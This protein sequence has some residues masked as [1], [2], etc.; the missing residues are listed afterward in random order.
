MRLYQKLSE[1][2][3]ILEEAQKEA[4]EVAFIARGDPLFFGIGRRLLERFGPESLEI[5]PAL[6]VVQQASARLKIPWED[7]WVIS[8]HGG[9]K[10][11][12][13]YELSEIPGLL[14]LYGKLAVFTDP[15][16]PP[17]EILAYLKERVPEEELEVWVAERLGYP[18]ERLLSGSA[19]ELSAETFR[20]PNLLFLRY[21][22][23]GRLRGLGLTDS[24]LLAPGGLF[25]KAEI[26]AVV[27]HKLRLPERGVLWDLGAG[28][29]G[30]SCEAARSY[31]LLRV[32]AVEKD[33]FRAELLFQNR[34]RLGLLNLEPVVGEAPEVLDRL[35]PPDRVFIGGTGGR[36]ME[37]LET[38]C[39]RFSKGPL[40]L[41]FT[42]LENLCQALEFLKSR[43]LFREVL[44]IKLGRSSP[45]GRGHFLRA[46]NPVFVV[47]AEA[48]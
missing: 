12:R 36:L 43:G 19:S 48:R 34:K 29:G 37:I 24:E 4:L 1:A 23:P 18:E 26:R 27:L 31:P 46:E 14:R 30:L 9:S 2:L 20:D 3:L 13:Y 33:L 6:S 38:V 21:S 47:V 25:T 5:I 42:V 17:E 15:Q 10:R 28:A 35:P 40:V 8:L 22:G 39:A 45:L 16:H 44:E 11:P 41:T 7:F 32:W